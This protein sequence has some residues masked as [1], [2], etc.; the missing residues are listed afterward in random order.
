MKKMNATWHKQ[1][2]LLEKAPMRERVIWHL[3]HQR[4]CG[5]RPIPKSVQ[6]AINESLNQK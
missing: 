1:N 6:K 3:A 5:C 4:H 2:V